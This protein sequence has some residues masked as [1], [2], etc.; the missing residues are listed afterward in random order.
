[1]CFGRREMTR[2]T[3]VVAVACALACGAG[4]VAR[5]DQ[6]FSNGPIITNPTGGTGAIAGLPISQ[7]EGFT[8][9]GSSFIFSTTGIGSTF[10]TN[11]KVAEDFTVPAGGWDLDS[12]TF[13][14]FQTSQTTATVHTIRVNLWTETP[15]SAG[16]PQPVPNPLPTPMLATS[17]VLSAG[18]GTFVCHREGP[19]STST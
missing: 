12:A 13:Y 3:G 5:A 6:L 7:A 18:P 17:L 15:Y 10:A 16:S 9:P 2:L 11:T 14:A 4:G 8:V 1:M 19:T